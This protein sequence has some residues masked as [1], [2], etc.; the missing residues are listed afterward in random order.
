MPSSVNRGFWEVG[1]GERYLC[2][3]QDVYGILWEQVEYSQCE[4]QAV[5]KRDALI[6]CQGADSGPYLVS[7]V[8]EGS[9]RFHKEGGQSPVIVE[10]VI[11]YHFMHLLPRGVSLRAKAVGCGLAFYLRYSIP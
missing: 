3:E 7:H 10:L 11:I 2:L 9:F 1:N 5:V 4:T 6:L 8:V